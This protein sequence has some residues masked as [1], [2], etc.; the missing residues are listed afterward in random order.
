MVKRASRTEFY[1]KWKKYL[2]LRATLYVWFYS[3]TSLFFNFYPYFLFL[4]ILWDGIGWIKLVYL[5]LYFQQCHQMVL[6]PCLEVPKVL[7]MSSSR[8]INYFT[9]FFSQLWRVRLWVINHHLYMNSQ[10]FFSLITLCHIIVVARSCENFCSTTIFL[11]LYCQD[12]WWRL[13]I[14]IVLVVEF[15]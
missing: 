8:T 5:L 1:S 9:I 6:T 12:Q 11:C 2:L 3:T 15:L 14:I 7:F 13:R 10:F 4:L